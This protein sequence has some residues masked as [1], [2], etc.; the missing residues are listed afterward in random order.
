M[1]VSPVTIDTTQYGKGEESVVPG[2]SYNL[3]KFITTKGIVKG[4]KTAVAA[5][6]NNKK[7]VAEIYTGKPFCFNKEII[8]AIQE[9]NKTVV[10]YFQYKGHV[11]SVTIPATVDASK[12]LE[13]AGFAGPLYVGQQLGTTKLV[14]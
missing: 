10:Y 12:V 3:S 6:N 1:A 9:G 11:Y 2:T 8:K 5:A 14:K 7:D 4:I 13:K